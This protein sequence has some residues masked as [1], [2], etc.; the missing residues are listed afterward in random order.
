MLRS[1][2]PWKKSF[3]ELIGQMIL[4]LLV[5]MEK[6]K[7]IY[8]IKLYR[9]RIISIHITSSYYKEITML[10][11]HLLIY[12]H[13]PGLN[14]LRARIGPNKQPNSTN[15]QTPFG[16]M[17]SCSWRI[18]RYLFFICSSASNFKVFSFPT[19]SSF[20]WRFSDWLRQNS[21]E[22]STQVAQFPCAMLT[23]DEIT[24]INF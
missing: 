22:T 13:L 16:T 10:Y 12:L 17:F 21:C 8:I 20:S 14:N 19:M 18:Y 7:C 6:Y 5:H 2:F 4:E 15:T 24:W 11:C 3:E 1:S 23:G 9:V